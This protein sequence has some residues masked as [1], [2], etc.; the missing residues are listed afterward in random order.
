M[1]TFNLQ[2]F[3]QSRRTVTIISDAV[4]ESRRNIEA[5]QSSLLSVDMMSTAN[6][7]EAMLK[8][9]LGVNTVFMDHVS[10]EKQDAKA[11]ISSLDEKVQAAP[12]VT[13]HGK[14]YT[15][16][17][18]SQDLVLDIKLI[19]VDGHLST[20]FTLSAKPA[21]ALFFNHESLF[22]KLT[23]EQGQGN[24][25]SMRKS[26][27]HAE[28]KH[29]INGISRDSDI[30]GSHL[31]GREISRSLLSIKG[32]EDE[33][34]SMR[35][36]DLVNGMVGQEETEEAM[37]SL[38]KGALS[39]QFKAILTGYDNMLDIRKEV[40]GKL[41]GRLILKFAIE[42]GGEPEMFYLEE[43]GK[44]K[45]FDSDGQR[46]LGRAYEVL[47]TY[48]VAKR[49]AAIRDMATREERELNR[50][51]ALNAEE[52]LVIRAE[53]L[54]RELFPKLEES[55]AQVAFVC[56]ARAC[57]P[58]K[59]VFPSLM[60]NAYLTALGMAEGAKFNLIA[61]KRFKELVATQEKKIQFF[62]PADEDEKK[63]ADWA[64][65]Q[66][67]EYVSIIR[68]DGTYK[69]LLEDEDGEFHIALK[70]G[71]K[72]I[73]ML[74]GVDEVQ[75]RVKEF[76]VGKTGISLHL[77]DL[78]L[79][80]EDMQEVDLSAMV[81]QTLEV[82]LSDDFKQGLAQYGLE[83]MLGQAYTFMQDTERGFTYGMLGQGKAFRVEGLHD[84]QGRE[85]Q[86][87]GHSFW[88]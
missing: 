5:S 67:G 29:E 53:Q 36:L 41:E 58:D 65:P 78:V 71:A 23:A 6:M 77:H 73:T 45:A 86:S 76:K 57:T 17:L 2:Q 56:V 24:S 51:R 22:S 20:L 18:I 15:V 8:Q 13:P 49:G 72:Q 30:Y 70:A 10:L 87:D 59:D 69:L 84:L 47:K 75:G 40:S 1:S 88:I 31:A 68:H 82:A 39:E 60:E 16:E 34:L 19:L 64:R 4:L 44:P 26:T 50:E 7:V 80:H 25:V 43:N 11:F 62:F 12:K 28:S 55:L 66:D 83:V 33:T 79:K 14:T 85:L 3:V 32:R 21:E 42:Q 81:S 27:W 74:Q 9:G 38:K 54:A 37:N 61:R 48:G 52:I 35:L 63:R 46:Y